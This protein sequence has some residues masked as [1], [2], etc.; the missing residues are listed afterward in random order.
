MDYDYTSVRYPSRNAERPA[1]KYRQKV[2]LLK[3]MIR[4]YVHV[5]F[6]FESGFFIVNNLFA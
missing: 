2:A 5:S 3:Q 1:G 6:N 4:E